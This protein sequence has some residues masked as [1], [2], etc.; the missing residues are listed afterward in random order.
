MDEVRGKGLLLGFELVRDKK[1][2]TPLPKSQCEQIF[3][4][5]LRRG[6]LTMSYSPRVRINPPLVITREQALEGVAILDEAFGEFL[7]LSPAS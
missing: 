1:S 6:L 7:M 3:Q 5:C 2:R 4:L